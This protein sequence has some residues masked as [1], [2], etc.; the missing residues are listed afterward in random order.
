MILSGN[1]SDYA[2]WYPAGEDGDIS[3]NA[4]FTV[5]HGYETDTSYVYA[6]IIE[7]DRGGRRKTCPDAGIG[8]YYIS[9]LALTGKDEK[10]SSAADGAGAIRSILC[11]MQT[12]GDG[13]VLAKEVIM[14]SE[15][16]KEFNEYRL[17]DKSYTPF[18][19]QYPED[20]VHR[21]CFSYDLDDY[22][23]ERSPDNTRL[24]QLYLNKDGEIVYAYEVYTP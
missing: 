18:Y 3:C 20:K 24:M 13:T 7:I 10:S 15:S 6:Y 11:E 9:S 19:I 2:F 5:V 23:G 8:T 21:L 17:A 12:P 22:I 1:Y 4:R 14:V 16:N